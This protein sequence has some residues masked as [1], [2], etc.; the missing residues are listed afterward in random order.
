MEA[1]KKIL[2][3]LVLSVLGRWGVLHGAGSLPENHELCSD[4]D[5][6]KAPETQATSALRGCPSSSSGAQQCAVSLLP[7]TRQHVRGMHQSSERGHSSEPRC[8]DGSMARWWHP[9][10]PGVCPVGTQ[11]D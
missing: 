2:H 11:G 4:T 5:K 10:S 1:I 8:Q 9:S 6:C 3:E 7:V